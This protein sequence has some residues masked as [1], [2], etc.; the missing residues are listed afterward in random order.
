MDKKCSK[1]KKNLDEAMF[2]KRNSGRPHSACKSCERKMARDWYQRNPNYSR[3][4]AKDWREQNLER[5]QEYRKKNREHNYLTEIKKKYGLSRE[6]FE[7]MYERQDGKCAI[8]ESEF[9][10]GGGKFAPHVDH[11][12]GTG[13]VRG[14]LCRSC[15]SAIGY[16]QESRKLIKKAEEYLLC[17]GY[18]AKS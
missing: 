6:N 8:C 1:C 10:W 2:Y 4:R 3:Q 5:V 7:S 11:C 17:H 13:V 14:I 16:F 9:V 15:N 18:S 12:H